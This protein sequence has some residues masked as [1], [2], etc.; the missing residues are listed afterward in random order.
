MSHRKIPAIR[1]LLWCLGAWQ[2]FKASP[3]P[4]FSMAMWLSLGMFLPVLNFF[5]LL[6]ITVFYGGVIYT[7]HR[8]T[9]GE[10]VWLG[11]FFNGFKSLSRFLSLFIVGL[12]TILFAF[13]SSSVLINALGPDVAQSLTQTGQPPSKELMETLLPVLLAIIMKLLPLG[14]VIS[15]VVFLAVPRAMLD[16]RLGLLALWDA[17]QALLTNIGAFLLFSIGTIAL[18]VL[19][20]FVLA[21]PLALISSTGALAGILQTFVFVFISTLG[22]ALYLNAMYIAWRDIFMSDDIELP[23]TTNKL[24][25]SQI[26]A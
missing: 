25:D 22:W 7:L 23:A 9:E 13:F 21:I 11:D 12:P 24:P 19:A 15:W 8:K 4:V 6:L 18:V 5:M 17:V 3:Q 26:E 20:S 14:I 10:K 16:K 2:N 1:G